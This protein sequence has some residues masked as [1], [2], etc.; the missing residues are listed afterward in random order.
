M[1][2]WRWT[3]RK[4]THDI[5]KRQ[6]AE[7]RAVLK[8]GV[9]ALMLP[10]II[11][12]GIRFGIFTPTEAAVKPNQVIFISTFVYTKSSIKRSSHYILSY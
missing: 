8:D 12:V 9:A 11:I 7:K 3:V 1:F 4:E 5:R 10:V 2:V 6:K